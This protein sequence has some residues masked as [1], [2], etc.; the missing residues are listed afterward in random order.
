MRGPYQTAVSAPVPGALTRRRAAAYRRPMPPIPPIPPI[1]PVPPLYWRRREPIG[2]IVLI[3]LGSLFL[4]GQMDIFN[5]RLIEYAWPLVLIG[6][7]VW[8]VV[9]RLG[10]SQGGS[11]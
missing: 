8:L 5:G 10:D 4:L 2:A 9:R 1:P 7:G 11:K 3:G 6:L